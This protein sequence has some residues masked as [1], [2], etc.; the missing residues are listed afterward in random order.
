MSKTQRI[1][2]G[3]AMQQSRVEIIPAHLP[4]AG[5][6]HERTF[7]THQGRLT[8]APADHSITSKEMRVTSIEGGAEVRPVLFFR[9]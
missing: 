3:H 2:F 9:G 8:Q 7:R 4:E 6:K 1:P 5:G